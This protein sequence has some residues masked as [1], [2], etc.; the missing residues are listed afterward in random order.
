MAI[1]IQNLSYTYSA[2]TSFSADA[3][4]G[5]TLHIENGEYVGLIGHTG[6]GK[7]TLVQHLNGLILPQ[8]GQVTV[9]GIALHGPKPDLT[10]LRRRVGLVF[11]YPEY[12]LFEATVWKDIAFGPKN[13][14][15]KEEELPGVVEEAMRMVG[16]SPD[17]A[18]KSPFDLS[19][20]QRRRVALAGVLAMRPSVLVMDEPIAGLDPAGRA[21]LLSLIRDYRKEHNATI[22]MIS[23]S[24]EDIA[25][26]TQ[27]V[28]VLNKGAVEMQ[29]TPKEVF[30]SGA[31]LKEMGLSLPAMAHLAESLRTKGAEVPPVITRADMAAYILA[32]AG[33]KQIKI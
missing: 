15:A 26:E 24:M 29:G 5:I 14:G 18:E 10:A 28:I 12:Q 32:A 23:H 25:A 30:S 1:D 6:S 31:R 8:S 20:G 19:G 17:L 33:A 11:Q 27:R 7:S 3:L 16:L 21:E 2:N 13:L 9:E 22:F 4:K